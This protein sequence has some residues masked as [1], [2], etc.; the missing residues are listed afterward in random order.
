[1]N[2]S[3][4]GLKQAPRQWHAFLTR[5]LLTLRDFC[6]V[7]RMLTL[8]GDEGR[9]VTAVVVHVDS[10]FTARQISGVIGLARYL[11]QMVPVNTLAELRCYSG[12]FSERITIR[13]C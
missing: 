13:E 2:K 1:M 11:N 6:S 9:V 7:L 10:T 4:N 8:F 12:F 5:C 3:L